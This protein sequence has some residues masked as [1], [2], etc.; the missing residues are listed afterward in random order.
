LNLPEPSGHSKAAGFVLAGGQSSRMGSDKALVELN[1]KPLIAGAISILRDAGLPAAIAGARSLLLKYAPVIEDGGLGPLQGICNALA[2][3]DA[4]HLVFLS[5][6]MPLIPASLI[7]ALLHNA[8]ITEAAAVFSSVNGFEETFP[9]VVDRAVLPAL[10]SEAEAGNTGCRSALCAA[11]ARLKRAVVVLG[12]ENL[13][14]SG[15]VEHPQGLPPALW[16]LNVNTPA[17]LARTEAIVG[18]HRV[19]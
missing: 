4:G 5:I 11:G 19:S 18:L 1:G 14:Q 15:H 3:T 16:F 13:V 12:V 6:D 9:C 17:E 10:E 7:V 8:R 2:S